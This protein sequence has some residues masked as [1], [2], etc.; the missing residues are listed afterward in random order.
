MAYLQELCYW[1]FQNPIACVA[2]TQYKLSEYFQIA[3]ASG[4]RLR[5]RSN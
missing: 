5:Y 2:S 3:I 1:V 4:E